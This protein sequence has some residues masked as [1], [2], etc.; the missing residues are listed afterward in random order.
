MKKQYENKDEKYSEFFIQLDEARESCYITPMFEYY[1]LFEE[2]PLFTNEFKGKDMYF[3]NPYFMQ[4][5]AGHS[6]PLFKWN[7][8]EGIGNELSGRNRW[9]NTE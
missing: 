7:T 1:T 6:I 4:T 8:F 9:R 2:L 3:F 5:T